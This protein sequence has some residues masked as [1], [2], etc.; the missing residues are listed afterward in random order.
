MLLKKIL[1]SIL[2]VLVIFTVGPQAAFADEL[3]P[4]AE[5][6]DNVLTSTDTETVSTETDSGTD[7]DTPSDT[8]NTETGSDS[9]SETTI[10]N[11]TGTETGTEMMKIW[12]KKPVLHPTAGCTPSSK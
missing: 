8:G 12:R 9:E 1:L 4:P 11:E 5:Q 6:T 3:I 10:D 2:C 7:P